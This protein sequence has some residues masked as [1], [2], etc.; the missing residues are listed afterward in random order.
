[1]AFPFPFQIRQVTGPRR[2]VTLRG[3]S[4]PYR[5]VAWGEK[6]RANFNWFPGN[7]VGAVQVLG[8]EFKPTTITGKWKDVFLFN[9]TNAADLINFPPLA[10]GAI[11]PQGISVPGLIPPG[12]GIDSA[13]AATLTTGAQGGQT[14]QSGMSIPANQPARRARTLRDAF[15]LIGGEGQIVRVEWGSVVRFGLLLDWDFPH[16]RE[17]DIAFT[18]KFGWLGEQLA[19][20]P[21]IIKPKL[22][23]LSLLEILLALLDAVL[24]AFLK[25]IALINERILRIGQLIRQLQAFIDDFGALLGGLIN[26]ALAPLEIIGGMRALLTQIRLTS[27]DL[28]REVSNVHSATAGL[29]PGALGVTAFTEILSLLKEQRSTAANLALGAVETL[30]EIDALDFNDLL[31]TFPVPGDITLR[32]VSLRFYG[33]ADGW[34]IIQARNG[35]FGSIVRRGTVLLIPKFP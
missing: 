20:D 28:M 5:P 14:F 27:L 32:D 1:M 10:A 3:R 33:T 24:N 35:L 12:S 30:A 8:I 21:I 25:L 15:R 16:D 23:L 4:L 13:N 22:D 2:L 18:M 11:P 6:Q 7:K 29:G 26:F 19:P 9:D 17:E 34:R 31:A